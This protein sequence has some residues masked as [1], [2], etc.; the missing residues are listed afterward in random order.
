[1]SAL[2]EGLRAGGAIFALV[3][4]CTT[5]A[6]AVIGMLRFPD[7]FSRVHAYS[8]A[9]SVGSF[10]VLAGLA[11]A[12]WEPAVSARLLI[13]AV[14]LA[15][16]GPSVAQAIAGAAHAAGLSPLAGSYIAPRPGEAARRR[17]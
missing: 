15:A 2:I 1:M 9:A 14:I 11:I 12:A 16:A 10:F 4:G 17:T 5:I 6:I 13:L 7:L 3:V 8:T